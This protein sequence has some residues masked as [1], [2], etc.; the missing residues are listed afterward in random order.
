MEEPVRVVLPLCHGHVVGGVELRGAYGGAYVR[1]WVLEKIELADDGL[2]EGH[3]RLLAE[4]E[5]VPQQWI[6][7]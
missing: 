4:G 6:D 2:L 1:R 5:E 3:W 7:S